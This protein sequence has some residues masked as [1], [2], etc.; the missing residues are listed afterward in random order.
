MFFRKNKIYKA[1]KKLE[2]DDNL[3]KELK[4]VFQGY[5]LEN[6]FDLEEN[7]NDF[8]IRSKSKCKGLFGF[9]R[10]NLTNDYDTQ[11]FNVFSK[12][13][14][15][16][17]NCFSWKESSKYKL[18]DTTLRCIG[19]FCIVMDVSKMNIEISHSVILNKNYLILLNF[20]EI[21]SIEKIHK[22]TTRFAF[23]FMKSISNRITEDEFF[24]EVVKLSIQKYK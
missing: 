16:Y 7:F 3:K 19:H 6:I 13:F 9:Y 12:E 21:S 8:E 15:Y 20:D 4:N 17:S 11:N 10:A 2:N 18:L 24:N 5:N 22:E 23:E 1:L 14:E